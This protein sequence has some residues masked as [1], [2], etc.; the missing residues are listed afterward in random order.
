[1]SSPYPEGVLFRLVDK[2]S[3]NVLVAAEDVRGFFVDPDEEPPETV[4]FVRAHRV[5]PKAGKTERAEFEVVGR[6]GKTIGAYDVGRVAAVLRQAS[7]STDATHA[8]PDVEYALFGHVCEFPEAGE[9]WRRWAEGGPIEAGEWR[10]YPAGT[11]KSWLH[12]VQTAWF[13]SGRRA[14]R[15]SPVET[16]VIEGSGIVTRA[17][18]YCAVG[19]AVN[20]PGGY[21][22]SNLDALHDCLRTMR[23][24][25][26]RPLRVLWRDFPASRE[27]LGS[28]YT[29]AVRSV[30]QESGVE[31]ER[32]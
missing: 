5:D 25:S 32:G 2:E 19:E 7:G 28:D 22:G 13:S 27:A 8:R 17:A 1:M 14:T 24:D 30:F 18:L 3:R 29:D 11:Q 12:V 31:V 15:Y 10:R 16:A 23:R 26:D 9:M 21:F 20:G 6:E 4:T